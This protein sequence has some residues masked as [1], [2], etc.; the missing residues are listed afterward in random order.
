[1][2]IPPPSGRDRATIH[3]IRDRLIDGGLA[4]A[5]EIDQHLANL[6][7]GETGDLVTSPMIT[8]WDRKP[9]DAAHL[10]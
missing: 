6:T 10:G 2:H 5:A 9:G 1:V 4:T 8:A 3:Q 7:A